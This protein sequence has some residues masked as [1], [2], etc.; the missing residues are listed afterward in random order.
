LH[1]RPDLLA[2]MAAAGQV[3]VPTLAGYYWMAGHGD[4]GPGTATAGEP[5]AEMTPML[6]DLAERNID[7]GAAT[8]QAAQR[9]GVKIAL[10]SDVSLG[11]ALELQLMIRHG[12]TPEQALTA[13]TRTAADALDLAEH[14]GTVEEGKLADLLI[15]D[16]DPLDDPAMLADPRG[17]WLVLQLGV[18]VAGQ[19]LEQDW[20]VPKALAHHGG[21]IQENELNAP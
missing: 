13:A 3:L 1:R 7:D 9:A 6:A 8:L 16:G 21:I 17:I 5:A 12:L 11:T 18:P 15:T 4:T 10:G 20:R 19:A 14:I 2:A